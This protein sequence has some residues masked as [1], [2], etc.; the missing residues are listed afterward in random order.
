MDTYCKF[1][2]SPNLQTYTFVNN[3]KKYVTDKGLSV[4]ILKIDLYKYDK[5]KYRFFQ[6]PNHP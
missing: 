2:L 1:L 4:I 6:D 3:V 5:V